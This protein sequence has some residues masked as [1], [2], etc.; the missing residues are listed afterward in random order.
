MIEPTVAIE[1][2]E[3]SHVPPVDAL[4]SVVV[5]VKQSANVP[6]IP[7]GVLFTVTVVVATLPHPVE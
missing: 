3:L 2:F 7:A 5:P 4:V 1:V 6:P